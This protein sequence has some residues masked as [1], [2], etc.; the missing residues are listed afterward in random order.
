MFLFLNSLSGSSNGSNK[1]VVTET[2]TNG[3]GQLAGNKEIIIINKEK[4]KNK[5]LQGMKSLTRID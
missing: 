4:L 1:S 2:T 5:N 3:Y